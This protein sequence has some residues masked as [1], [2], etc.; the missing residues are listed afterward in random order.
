MN[1]APFLAHRPGEVRRITS[2][3]NEAVKA[4]RSLELKKN[5]NETGL[6]VAEGARTLIEAEENGAD[7][8]VL[9]HHVDAAAEAAVARLRKAVIARGGLVLEVDRASLEKISKRENPQAVV[10]VV[11]QRWVELAELTA[12]PRTLLL[13]QVRDPGNLGT[14]LRTADA[15]GA[16]AVILAGDCTD[17]YGLDAV[18]AS[19]GSVFAVDL[20]RAQVDAAVAWARAAGA[21]LVGTHLDAA[22]D[23]RALRWRSPAVIAMGNEQQ[24]LS[25]ELAAACDVRV[26]IPMAGRADSLNLAVATAITL[27]ESVRG[28]DGLR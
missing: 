28:S 12:G 14:I 7:I 19:M 11:R 6:F 25:A 3:A 17:P 5:R 13:E 16:R 9:A 15:L 18:R 27:F 22:A 2:P 1:A 4:I 10:G 24:G 20:V 8:V 26:R 23:I 21:H